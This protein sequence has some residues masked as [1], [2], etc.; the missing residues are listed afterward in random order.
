[1][2]STRNLALLTAGAWLCVGAATMPAQAQQ[3]IQLPDPIIGLIPSASDDA[4]SSHDEVA[5]G[6]LMKIVELARSIGGGITQLYSTIV[7]Q[8]AALEK[9]RDAQN[10][11][12]TI[13]LHNG[14]EEQEERAG[15]PG[16]AEM[17][18]G[19]LDGAPVEP[20]AVNEALEKFRQMFGLD[21]TFALKDSDITGKVFIANASAHGA[22]S[23]SVAEAGYKRANSSMDRLSSYISAVEN[24]ADLKTSI[25]INTRVMIELTQQVNESLRTQSAIASMVGMYF[26]VLGGEVG[27]QS[28]FKGLEEYNR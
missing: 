25:D 9:M 16:L 11:L 8:T 23:S 1:M 18:K 6:Q 24:S 3:L 27:K 19:A 14:P 20:E 28:P 26:M 10:G 12:K 22:I 5:I 21:E 13:P 7:T 4:Q 15:G 17:A 2:I